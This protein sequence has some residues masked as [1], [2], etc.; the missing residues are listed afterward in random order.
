MIP[1]SASKAEPWMIIVSTVAASTEWCSFTVD[2]DLNVCSAKKD[3][4]NSA[5]KNDLI[6]AFITYDLIDFFSESYFSLEVH[7]FI[8]YL[9]KYSEIPSIDMDPISQKTERYGC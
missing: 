2:N 4:A 9:T 3:S 8:V 5:A 1:M 6:A 7:F